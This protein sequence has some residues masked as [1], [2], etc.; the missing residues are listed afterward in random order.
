MSR[1]PQA[2]SKLPPSWWERLREDY[3]IWDFPNVEEFCISPPSISLRTLRNAQQQGEMTDK[4]L[5]LI[6][7]KLGYPTRE[8]MLESWR[9]PASERPPLFLVP[10]PPS[11]FFTGREELLG[12]IAGALKADAQ[13]RTV[14]LVGPPG[15]GKTQAA[16]SY[17]YRGKGNYRDVFWFV[18]DDPSM[19]LAQYCSLANHLGLKQKTEARQE[20]VRDAVRIW[21]DRHTDW[22]LVFDNVEDFGVL[23]KYI[24]RLPGGDVII[25]TRSGETWQSS[26]ELIGPLMPSEAQRLLLHRSGRDS[27][28]KQES[29]DAAALAAELGNF[30]LAL[31]QAGA[32]ISATGASFRAYLDAFRKAPIEVLDRDAGSGGQYGVTLARAWQLTIGRL[33]KRAAELLSAI[34]LC[35][36]D[37]IPIDLLSGG[38]VGPHGEVL[39][40][41]GAVGE[42]RRFSLVAL[43][44]ERKALSIHR[45]LRTLAY[46]STNEEDRRHLLESLAAT[47]ARLLPDSPNGGWSTFDSILPHIE[48]AMIVARQNCLTG[49]ALVKITEQRGGY[50]NVRGRYEEAYA[51]LCDGLSMAEELWPEGHP[52]TASILNALG[53]SCFYL[54]RFNQGEEYYK[55]SLALRDRLLDP[56]DPG[57]GTSLNNLATLHLYQGRYAEAESIF[58]RALRH[59]ETVKG[60]SHPDVATTSCNLA[61]LY[62]AQGKFPQAEEGY[63]RALRIREEA[64]VNHEYL[65]G[66]ILTNYAELKLDCEQ[67]EAALQLIDDALAIFRDSVEMDHAY[68]L[69]ARHNL[70]KTFRALG[71]AD[72]AEKLFKDVIERRR[73][74]FGVEHPDLAFTYLELGALYELQERTTEATE[75]M[76]I[77]H[78][79]LCTALGSTHPRT[80][81]ATIRFACQLASHGQYTEALE[82]YR[83]ALPQIEL[84]KQLSGSCHPDYPK[85]VGLCRDA[86]GPGTEDER[87]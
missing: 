78:Q 47:M 85:Y 71:Q 40:F 9:Q 70:A 50:L 76:R 41:E 57:I 44:M 80:T 11:Q 7:E 87:R 34:S 27:A 25:T 81:L 68:A 28:N 43:N 55:R 22:L 53:N 3:L 32:F 29:E 45:L 10:H 19:L 23:G 79:A 86:L 6:A 24:P 56:F 5:D 59:R 61:N 13:R 14:V 48:S 30:P 69:M 38:Y 63:R 26:Y 36:P 12:R 52:G 37:A 58:E 84:L 83:A 54:A 75:L 18:C 51:A 21:I 66:W 60:V 4:S 33:T 2:K 65:T 72:K 49:P 82:L 35:A 74:V 17:A 1:G 46:A 67:P 8:K 16:L 20:V 39:G 73:H 31:D 42:L 77:A 62:H 15:I 64:G